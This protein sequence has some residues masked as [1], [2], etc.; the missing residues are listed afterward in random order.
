LAAEEIGGFHPKMLMWR[1]RANQYRLL[2]GSS[3]LSIAAF[4]SNHEANALLSISEQEFAAVRAW[5]SEVRVACRPINEGWLRQ[6][7]ESTSHSKQTRKQAQ[8]HVSPLQVPSSKGINARLPWRRAK[9][10]AF[11][12]IAG[13]LRRAV[14]LCARAKITNAQFY[15]RMCALWGDHTSRF[16]GQGFQIR[17]KHAKW[18]QVCR[19][20]DTILSRAERIGPPA[21][22]AVVRAELDRLAEER[23]AARR[24]WL[25]EMLCH[26]FPKSYPL[27]DA[28]VVGWLRANK[29]RAPR[30]SSEGA[31]YIDLARKMRHVVASRHNP[32]IRDLVELDFAVW[33]QSIIKKGES[34]TYYDN[35]NRP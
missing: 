3:N 28:P 24:S 5:I 34:L 25:T 27:V 31:A 4:E 10:R 1:T 22:D 35:Y 15:D 29:Y 9:Q 14:G 33:A 7:R 19:S 2:V 20:L 6:Y 26:Y 21:L 30:G 8:R 13:K 12:Q 16:M 17:G 18:Q 23:N 32:H 11:G